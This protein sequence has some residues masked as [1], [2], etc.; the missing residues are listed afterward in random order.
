MMISRIWRAAGLAW[1]DLMQPTS[2]GTTPYTAAASALA[3]AV[4]GATA[5][6]LLGMGYGLP[7]ALAIAVAYWLA[8]ERADLRRRGAV[9]DGLEDALMVCLGAFYTGPW[10]W[11]PVMLLAGGAVL[12]SR[13]WRAA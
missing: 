12:I 4:L 8:K 1:A 10:W 13:W 6:A 3:H 11:P 2:A 5:A 9:L 7:G